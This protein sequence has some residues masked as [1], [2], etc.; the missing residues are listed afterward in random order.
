[1]RRCSAIGVFIGAGAKIIG[2]VRVGNDARIGAN[3]VVV[4]DVPP[5]APSWACRRGSSAAA[6]AGSGDRAAPAA[7]SAM[8]LSMRSGR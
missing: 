1:M 8:A 4:H 2:G 6:R 5:T 3:A 7:P